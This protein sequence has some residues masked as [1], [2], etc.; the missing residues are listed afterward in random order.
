MRDVP[1]IGRVLDALGLL[2]FLAGAGVFVRAWLGF[3]SVPEVAPGLDDGPWAAL[4]YADSFRRLQ[5]IGVG[6]MAAGVALFVLAWWIARRRMGPP[7]G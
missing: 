3:R 5:W 7:D 4:A 1:L 2:V 6:V